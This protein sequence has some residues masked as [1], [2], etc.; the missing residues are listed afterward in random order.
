MLKFD[1]K[2]Q[3]L[4]CVERSSGAC[5]CPLLSTSAGAPGMDRSQSWRESVE[6]ACQ[7]L[8][9]PAAQITH[10]KEALIMRPVRKPSNFA[11]VTCQ[12]VGVVC[13]CNA[14][15][16]DAMRSLNMLRHGPPHL[17]AGE[18]HLGPVGSYS[19]PSEG[20]FSIMWVA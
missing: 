20:L 7:E 3:T 10:V 15:L 13:T 9:L 6:R 17:P 2:W 5:S 12:V 18:G 11:T 14:W 19:K 16:V 4:W 8:R 1:I